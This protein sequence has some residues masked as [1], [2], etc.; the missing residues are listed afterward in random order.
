MSN[1][2]VNPTYGPVLEADS[3][4]WDKVRGETP[5]VV[6]VKFLR[7]SDL[8]VVGKARRGGLVAEVVDFG[9][10]CYCPLTPQVWDINVKSAVLLVK[11]AYPHLKDSG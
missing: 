1:A 2:A 7:Q 8:R 11:E 9:D 3:S 5:L 10:L 6:G 4:V